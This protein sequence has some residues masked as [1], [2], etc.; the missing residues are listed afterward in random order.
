M[1]QPIRAFSIGLLT[2]GIIF[3]IVFFIFGE[4]NK[5]VTEPS[6]EEMIETLESNGFHV[7]SDSEYVSLS[8][9]NDQS[10]NG[11]K[12]D[13]NNN[14]KDE[15]EEDSDKDNDKDKKQDEDKSEE[16]VDD[17]ASNGNADDESTNE[18]DDNETEEPNT[19]SL[20]IEEG[21]AS[22]EISAKLEDNNIIDDANKFNRFLE[23]EGYELKVQIGTFDVSDDMD[24]EEIANTIT[25]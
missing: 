22:S 3:L 12:E 9:K 20:T 1:K 5:K 23:T 14:G 17:D 25:K 4:A 16:D 6:S 2:S 18:D 7:L 10:E 8:V 19:Y 21:M 24:F 13:K 15:S 11:S